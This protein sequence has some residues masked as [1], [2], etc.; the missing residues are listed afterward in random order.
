MAA[1]KTVCVTLDGLYQS[2]V[3]F[4]GIFRVK[5][6]RAAICEEHKVCVL[7]KEWQTIEF[8]AD[9][10]ATV[11]LIP[12]SMFGEGTYYEYE[13]KCRL[14]TGAYVY[15]KYGKWK[16]ITKGVF[17]APDHDCNF[18]EIA[19]VQ[20][21]A[22]E[23]IEAA[24]AYASEAKEC[25]NKVSQVVADFGDELKAET[26]ERKQAD[27]KTLAAAKDY[28]DEAIAGIDLSP[29]AEK[30]K[31]AAETERA[32]SAELANAQAI[33]S[34]ATAREQG[35]NETLKCA[36]EYADAAVGKIDLTPYA[37]K[38][39]D[40]T[41]TGANTFE[42]AVGVKTIIA[43]EKTAQGDTIYD[44]VKIKKS[45]GSDGAMI[46]FGGTNSG[47]GGIV[48]GL[49]NPQQIYDATSKYYVDQQISNLANSKASN[50]ALEQGLAGKSDKSHTHNIS[51]INN[52]LAALESLD[53]S[54]GAI[55]GDMA[56]KSEL[57]KKANKRDTDFGKCYIMTD[58]YQ[59]VHDGAHCIVR[60]GVACIA[61]T[62]NFDY[63]KTDIIITFD[64]L[65]NYGLVYI[66]VGADV[67]TPNGEIWKENF[68]ASKL[69]NQLGITPEVGVPYTLTM[70]VFNNNGS[71]VT[72]FEV[73]K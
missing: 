50:T 61:L 41:F 39:A 20:P 42:G 47:N 1:M 35:D 36:T 11:D 23:P 6:N 31:L 32:K 67:I 45:D 64:T 22:E 29:Y 56:T 51:D 43:N 44:S 34:E 26:E 66:R 25:V 57:E 68:F 7:P 53:S 37:K 19:T 49:K 59:E 54:I 28:T 21:M 62:E 58:N 73:S 70:R 12:N 46:D 13:I 16:C 71:T 52:L 14:N 69:F 60:S 8:T 38:N 65:D 55:Y 4:D 33:Q 15:D 48:R 3:P 2:A 17:V 63:F 40:N 27:T 30:D 24:K 18:S 10:V 5:L 72:K 9:G